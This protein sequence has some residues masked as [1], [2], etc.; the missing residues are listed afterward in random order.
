MLAAHPC[1]AECDWSATGRT[2]AGGRLFR[3]AGCGS[4]W[5][6]AQP[7]TPAQADGTVPP[8][9]T[10]ELTSGRGGD[11]AGSSGRSRTTGS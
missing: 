8:A 10:A 11:A 7:W 5:T 6:A 1:Q 3:C 9:V 4:E 2:D